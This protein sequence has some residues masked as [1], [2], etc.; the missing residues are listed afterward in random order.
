MQQGLP[1]RHDGRRWGFI[2]TTR[3]VLTTGTP[4]LDAGGNLRGFD[5]TG[6]NITVPVAGPK[7]TNVDQVDRL[8]RAVQ[9]NAAI[10]D[11]LGGAPWPRP[12]V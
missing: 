12:A 1:L 9:A 11:L 7:V 6:G 4:L 5:A 3:G 10:S 2:N 8:A